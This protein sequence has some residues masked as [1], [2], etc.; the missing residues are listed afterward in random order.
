MNTLDGFKEINGAFIQPEDAMA[1]FPDYCLWRYTNRA[2]GL[3]PLSS[4]PLQVAYAFRD[5]RENGNRRFPM[6][7]RTMKACPISASN[8]RTMEVNGNSRNVAK[9]YNG[10]LS[11]YLR[12]MISFFWKPMSTATTHQNGRYTICCGVSQYRGASHD[13]HRGCFFSNSSP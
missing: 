3:D 2:S 5:S 11:G 4:E 13:L 12:I 10:V 8:R 9:C 7:P 1:E 6:T